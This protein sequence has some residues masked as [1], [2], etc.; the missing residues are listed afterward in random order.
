MRSQFSNMA[1]LRHPNNLDKS[2]KNSQKSVSSQSLENRR[3]CKCK[4]VLVISEYQNTISLIESVVFTLD[5]N[6]VDKA[7]DYRT[8]IEVLSLKLT[9]MCC[10]DNYDIIFIDLDGELLNQNIT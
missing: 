6:G 8:A 9:A 10:T 2:P 4:S 5:T 1:H 7:G 3:R